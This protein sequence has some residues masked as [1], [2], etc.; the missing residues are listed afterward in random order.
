MAPALG[1]EAFG[2]GEE[3]GVALGDPL[4]QEEIGVR[5]DAVAVE[6]E[7]V[8]GAAAYAP[9]GRVE[10]HRFLDYHLGVGEMREIGLAPARD[11]PALREVPLRE[12]RLLWDFALVNT[13]SS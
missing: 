8:D 10:A 6:F 5:G 13:K 7:V 12:L 3:A 9:G 4:E 1:V 11:L 2:V